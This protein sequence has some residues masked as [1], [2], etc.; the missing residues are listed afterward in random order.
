VLLSALIAMLGLVS[1]APAS[2]ADG[3]QP[4]QIAGGGTTGVYYGYGAAAA[5]VLTEALD[6]PVE[7]VETEG[8]VDNLRRVSGGEAVFGFA[9]SDAAVD[10]LIGAGRFD[11]PAPVRAVARLYDEYVHV[12]VRAQSSIV[13]IRDLAE[14]RFSLGAEGS[15]VAVVATRVLEAAGIEPSTVRD[16]R[17]GVDASIQALQRGEIDGFFW[18]GGLPTPGI[19]Q[20]A[21]RLPIRLLP[22]DA[23]IVDRVNAVH[24]GV[25]RHAEFPSGA[26]GTDSTTKAMTVPN[27]LVTSAHTSDELVHGALAALFRSRRAMSLTVPS[28]ALLDLRQAIFTDPIDLHPGAARFYREQRF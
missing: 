15:G 3:T 21:S 6:T 8:S 28:A 14:R 12:V 22:I 27:Y 9:Q 7:V 2:H 1:C 26:Y 18:V 20:L 10:A 13:S 19:E 24:G 11:R 5:A 16:P 25:Y 4:L 23:D 17:L